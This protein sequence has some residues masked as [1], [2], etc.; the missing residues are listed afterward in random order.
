LP[1]RISPGVINRFAFLEE[2]S[3][4]DALD[5]RKAGNKF[6]MEMLRSTG[7]CP[8]LHT[9]KFQGFPL[10]EPLFEVMRR[11]MIDNVQRITRLA[12]RALPH[13]YLLRRLVQLLGGI[14]NVYTTRNVDEIIAKR[15]SC[16]Y[17]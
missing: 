3:F 12:L 13:I 16:G 17:L 5:E 1:T 6:L 11:R 7:S 8:R 14:S 10:W 9:I 2:I 15:P 4:R